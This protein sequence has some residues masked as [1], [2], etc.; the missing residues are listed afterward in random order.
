MG[1]VKQYEV[2]VFDA[3]ALPEAVEYFDAHN[4]VQARRDKLR[5]ALKTALTGKEISFKY[6]GEVRLGMVSDLPLSGHAIEY[7]RVV[8]RPLKIGGEPSKKIINIFLKD[9]RTVREE[10]PL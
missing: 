8:V 9:I 6:S 4:M 7:L 1:T 10:L 3:L 5:E 2:K